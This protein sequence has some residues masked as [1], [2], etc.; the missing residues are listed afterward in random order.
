MEKP[1][2][3]TIMRRDVLAWCCYDWANSGYTTLVITVFVVYL[4]RVIFGDESWG[5]TGP[6][7]WAWGV[8][9]SMLVGAVLSPLLGALA[10]AQGSKCK[11]LAI[12]ALSGAMACVA[13]ALVPT[14]AVWIA[15]ACFVFANLCLELSLTVYN[16][17][18]PEIAHDEEMNRVSSAGMGWGYFGGGLWLSLAML[19]LSFG[20]Q[21]GITEMS[22]RLRWCI[23]GTGVWWA[24][25]TIPTLWMLR[26]KRPAG[27]GNVGLVAATKLAAH[28]AVA[29]L[30][31]VRRFATLAI[32]LVA[33]L[34]FNDGIQTV[35]SQSS[36][37]ALQEVN[38]TESE[39]LGV[40]LMVQFLAVPGALLIGRLADA[41][42]QKAALVVCLMIWIGL[43]I[44]AWFVSTKTA[45]WM[46][47]AGVALVLGGTQAVSRAI[48]GVLTPEVHA[49]KFFGFF[50]LS[51]KTTS[52]MG[53]FLFGA[54]IAWTGS[55][56]LA[57][58]NLL[59]FFV[60]GL[61]ILAYV[62]IE[63]GI[64]QREALTDTSS[65]NVA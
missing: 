39:L 63:R 35:I 30:L 33:F 60:I 32:F 62:N 19:V 41:K 6:V 8:S 58:V 12:T 43:L 55:S 48:M 51:G 53:T 44:S 31:Q 2:P 49:A 13:M 46:M 54:V 27:R 18:L 65:S 56:R 52:F 57:V 42:G 38:F 45:Y 14:D 5:N 36:T 1:A 50:N 16:G 22:T 24:L 11:W 25:F 29:T 40:I 3:H 61:V 4:Q 15:T 20:E 28:D 26:D 17:F 7:V 34:F 64:R 23:A 37:F 9:A 10:D 47:A 59:V 21:L